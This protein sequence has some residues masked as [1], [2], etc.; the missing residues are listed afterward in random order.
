MGFVAIRVSP[1]M[2][3]VTAALLCGFVIW[4]SAKLAQ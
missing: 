3:I 1:V 2:T 4:L